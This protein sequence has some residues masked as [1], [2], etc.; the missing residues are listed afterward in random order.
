MLHRIL[1]DRYIMPVRSQI[2]VSRRTHKPRF[3]LTAI[4]QSFFKMH[5]SLRSVI[6]YDIIRLCDHNIKRVP[7]ICQTGGIRFVGKKTVRSIACLVVVITINIVSACISHRKQACTVKAEPRLHIQIS[8][9]Q[10][11]FVIGSKGF[12]HFFLVGG[13]HL[14]EVIAGSKACHR[15]HSKNH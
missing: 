1:H 7:R 12:V 2:I 4:G 14:Q 9:S 3:A 11:Q 6:V 15:N 13:T 5:P 8:R 10:T